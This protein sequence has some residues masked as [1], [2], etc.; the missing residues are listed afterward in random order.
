MV[1]Q[2]VSLKPSIPRRFV[3]SLEL[4][5]PLAGCPVC[6]GET[7]ARPAVNITPPT[8]QGQN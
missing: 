4:I 5:R 2:R 6:A 3:K 1:L 7:E 8:R